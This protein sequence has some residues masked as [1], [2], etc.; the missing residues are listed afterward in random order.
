MTSNVDIRD[1]TSSEK[2]QILALYPQIFPEEELRPVVSELL[3]GD[4]D[5]L[6]LAAFDGDVAVGHV[7]FSI[8]GT[9]TVD[10]VGAVLGPL[11]VLPSVQRDGLGSALVRTGLKR[12]EDRGIRQV[13]VLGDPG[14]YQR[15]GFA[16]E[17]R[18]MPPYPLPDDWAEAWESMTLADRAPLAEGRLLPPRTLD[19]TRAV[20]AM[21]E[22]PGASA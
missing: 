20:G 10:P 5:I 14:Y 22:T 18:V 6:S 11:G 2:A 1:T 13:F 16:T 4:F 17:R 8:C 3:E 7:L 12:L 21:T 19:E 15:F 9:D